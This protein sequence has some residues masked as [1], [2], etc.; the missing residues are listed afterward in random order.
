VKFDDAL[1]TLQKINVTIVK[2]EGDGKK[3]EETM[4]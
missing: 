2:N 4:R 1:R 3:Q